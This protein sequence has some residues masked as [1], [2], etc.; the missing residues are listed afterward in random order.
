[1]V[2][3]YSDASADILYSD[4]LEAERYLG[5]PNDTDSFADYEDANLLH[6][7]QHVDHHQFLLVHGID[8][9][10][11]HVDHSLSLAK[12]QHTYRCLLE[13]IYSM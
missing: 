10:L 3:R 5:F 7:L 4:V 6:H 8:D 11:V 2:G 9:L 1:M 12:V 13:N